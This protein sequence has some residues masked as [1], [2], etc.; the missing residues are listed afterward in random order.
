MTIE[1]KTSSP[2]GDEDSN[3]LHRRVGNRIRRA[4]HRRG[5]SLTQLG[6]GTLS[7]S[8]LSLVERGHTGIS[9][10]ALALVAEQLELPLG[11]FVDERPDLDVFDPERVDH[12]KAAVAY[13]RLVAG[14]GDFAEAWRYAIWAAEARY[15]DVPR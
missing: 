2:S 14:R 15:S 5:L 4:R 9:L 1:R 11:Y 10:R 13:S 12:V 7:R 3:T 6:N 8:F